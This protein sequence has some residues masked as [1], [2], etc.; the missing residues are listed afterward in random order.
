MVLVFICVPL[1]FILSM[2]SRGHLASH[3]FFLLAWTRA[4]AWAWSVFRG[5]DRKATLGSV[6]R[7]EYVSD[8]PY[9]SPPLPVIPLLSPLPPSLCSF[10]TPQTSRR[11]QWSP[12]STGQKIRPS[13]SYRTF[14][15]RISARACQP[16]RKEG[17]RASDCSPQ[18]NKKP[19][20]LSS[21]IYAMSISLS[22]SI[23]NAF[24]I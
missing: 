12:L 7:A 14:A 2:H 11:A 4:R 18:S 9:R 1:H 21:S 15:H 24:Q 6:Q 13:V 3:F 5:K 20:P 8:R 17:K 19:P 22:M 16:K 23:V 10:R